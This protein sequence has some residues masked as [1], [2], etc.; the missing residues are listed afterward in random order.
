ML[1]FTASQRLLAYKR[2]DWGD[3]RNQLLLTFEVENMLNTRKYR[4]QGDQLV[5][6]TRDGV[7]FTVGLTWKY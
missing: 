5:Y 3:L 7:N 2:N 6:S 4:T 1:D